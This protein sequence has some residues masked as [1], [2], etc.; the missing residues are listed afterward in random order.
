MARFPAVDRYSTGAAIPKEICVRDER[1]ASQ[2]GAARGKLVWYD[3][4]DWVV[5]NVHFV[6]IDVIS[7][8]IRVV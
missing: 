6:R 4:L 2:E 3:I 7:H 8:H 5:E 1:G